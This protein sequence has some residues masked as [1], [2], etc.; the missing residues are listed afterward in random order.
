MHTPLQTKYTTAPGKSYVES[1]S[2]SLP[3]SLFCLPPLSPGHPSLSL[4]PRGFFESAHDGLGLA[5]RKTNSYRQKNTGKRVRRGETRKFGRP[6][7]T[8]GSPR[9]KNI[10]RRENFFLKKKVKCPT[11][12]GGEFGSLQQ[13]LIGFRVCGRNVFSFFS[14]IAQ[15][16]RGPPLRHH[17]SFIGLL[18]REER[19]SFSI[20]L[21]CLPPIAREKK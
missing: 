5:R 17:S 8:L 19:E 14:V 21:P 20:C 16:L 2:S 11:N 6:E 7:I 3:H 4:F 1:H 18:G 10:P 13:A 12:S 9:P 15:W